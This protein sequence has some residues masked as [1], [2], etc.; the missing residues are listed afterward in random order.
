MSQIIMLVYAAR[1]GLADAAVKL[2][3]LDYVKPKHTALIAR[4]ESG[5]V[6]ILDDDINPN[7]GA[8]A[9]GTLGTIM[10]AMGVAQLGA[11]L[12]P[13]IGPVIAL[14][15]GALVG[16]LVGGVAGSAAAAAIDMGINDHA[17]KTLAG[18]LEQDRVALVF[19]TDSDGDLIE[20]LR[21]D[22]EPLSIESMSVN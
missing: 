17:L 6:T 11:L 19:E 1:T 5:E 10:G 15:A 12:L 7:E 21:A 8:V 3:D 9:G 13:G 16:A 22:L 18:H 4:A 2:L 20:R 14:G